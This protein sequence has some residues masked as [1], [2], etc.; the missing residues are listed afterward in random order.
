MMD[1]SVGN[2]EM[3]GPLIRMDSDDGVCVSLKR[4][5]GVKQNFKIYFT[6]IYKHKY[7]YAGI[8]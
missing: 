7:E 8:I 4:K 3:L 1:D 5:Q 2:L 6:R